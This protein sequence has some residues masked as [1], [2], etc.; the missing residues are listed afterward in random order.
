MFRLWIILFS[1]FAI[2]TSFVY[3][4]CDQKNAPQSLPDARI[5]AGW[6][7]WQEKNCQSCHQMYGLGG[8]LGPD[9]TNVASDSFKGEKY[10]YTFIKYG[11]GR[12]PNFN[13]NDSEVN[14]L[15][16]FL[17]WVDRSGKNNVPGNK[18]TW[19][20]NYNLDN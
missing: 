20:G 8:Y 14:H 18:V 17:I 5:T 7:I 13:L 15:V 6:A 10:L 4:R 11:T 1:V 9:L 19:A 3:T 16:A 12:M 2:Y